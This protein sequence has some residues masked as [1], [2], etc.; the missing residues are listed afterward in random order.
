MHAGAAADGQLGVVV[1][2]LLLLRRGV[3]ACSDPSI[4][5]T[6][7]HFPS[8]DRFRSSEQRCAPRPTALHRNRTPAPRS[9]SYPVSCCF[10]FRRLMTKTRVM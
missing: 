6:P 2:R 8:I 1:V 4:V 5:H 3:H 7:L 10:S 9:R